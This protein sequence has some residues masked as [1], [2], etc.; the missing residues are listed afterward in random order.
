MRTKFRSKRW[1]N[2]ILTNELWAG[3]VEYHVL[4]HTERILKPNERQKFALTEQTCY[5]V[6]IVHLVNHQ[7]VLVGKSV[8]V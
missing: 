1:Q 7:C 4:Q 6:Y 2:E 5:T 3:H 8:V